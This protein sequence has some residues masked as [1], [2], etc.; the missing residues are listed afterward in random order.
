MFYGYL[1]LVFC[2]RGE[3]LRPRELKWFGQCHMDSWAL[4]PVSWLSLLQQDDACVPSQ[5]LLADTP[6]AILEK[7]LHM[8]VVLRVSP[9]MHSL[10]FFVLLCA[11][12]ADPWGPLPVPP[13]FHDVREN[14]SVCLHIPSGRF[15]C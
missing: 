9:Q 10:P 5:V 3:K 11:Q 12:E 15:W 2:F 8:L 1:S 4:D 6:S 14:W 7:L 13:S